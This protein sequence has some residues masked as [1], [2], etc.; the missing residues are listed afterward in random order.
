M[1]SYDEW[2]DIK[3]RLNKQGGIDPENSPEVK[4]MFKAVDLI[5][6]PENISGT[7]CGNCQFMLAKE[8]EI[9]FCS[10][11]S[12][13]YPVTKRN[14]CIFWTSKGTIRNF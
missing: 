14:C 7:N 6:L 1:K 4:K 5:T 10:H 8:S 11:K 12:I 13:L 3:K 2:A 9:G